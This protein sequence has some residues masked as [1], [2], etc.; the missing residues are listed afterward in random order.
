MISSIFNT[1]FYEP[2]YNGLIFL[3]S[4]IPNTD[5]G[6][7]IIILI[8]LVKFI[9]LPLSHK[10][11]KTQAKTKNIEPEV[12][13]L[14]DK[15]KEDK[16]EQARQI[17]ELYKKHGVNPMTGCLL[18]LIQLPIILALYHV[19]LNGIDEINTEIVYSFVKIP[20]IVN[21]NF[22]GIFDIT[23]KSMLLAL[24]AGVLQFYQMKFSLPPIQ[25]N[26]NTNKKDDK[27]FKAEFAKNMTTQMRY[28]IPVF[29]VFIAYS[30][31][32]AVALYLVVNSAFSI[33]HEL[34]VRKKALEIKNTTLNSGF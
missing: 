28:M 17:M 20:E 24:L 34:I 2:I 30:F 21:M 4:I 29:M 1:F 26:T 13:K 18:V 31:S 15:Y 22:L 11:I 7:A 12:K 6:I 10:S 8:I 19:F 33:I 16:Q 25:S 27:S 14:K 23:N 9:I 3:I 32:S 5:V